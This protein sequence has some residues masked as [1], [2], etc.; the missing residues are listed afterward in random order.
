MRRL[1]VLG[2]GTAGT[3][4]VN[5]LRH[6]LSREDWQISVVDSSDRHFYQP[7]YL[8]LPFG[9][10]TPDQVVRPVRRY[11]PDGVHLV[12][13]EV[14][15]VDPEAGEV[16]LTDGHRLSLETR[17]HGGGLRERE[18]VRLP[19]LAQRSDERRRV[20]PAR[21]RDQEM[22]ATFRRTGRVQRRGEDTQQARQGCAYRA[23]P[24]RTCVI[25]DSAARAKASASG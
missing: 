13:G 18:P 11:I 23:T 16:R 14:D 20:G 8:F 25:S 19:E 1:V 3:M 9:R 24:G 22:R 7:G 17:Q 12:Q 15:R 6:R 2:A 21:H 10:Y 5:K 4:V